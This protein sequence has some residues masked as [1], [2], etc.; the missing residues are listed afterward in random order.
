MMN[1]VI[2]LLCALCMSLGLQAHQ[3]DLSSTLLVEHEKD[4]WVLQVRA[5]LTAFKYEIEEHYGA[6][7]Y[8]SPAEFQD[9]VLKHVKENI[10]IMYNGTQS[11]ELKTGIVKLGHETSVTFAVEGTPETIHTL[12]VKN[13]SFQDVSR[14]QSALMILKKGFSKDQFT[15]NNANQH[16]ARLHVQDDTFALVNPVSGS[17]HYALWIFGGITLLTVLTL[18]FFYRSRQITPSVQAPSHA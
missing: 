15:L 12:D 17:R 4:Q 13:S 9:L 11:V 14:N 2:I 16:T 18:Y 3:P 8:A 6:A 1:R 7:S 10:F 5:S